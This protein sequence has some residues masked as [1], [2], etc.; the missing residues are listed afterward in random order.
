[1]QCNTMGVYCAQ[2]QI[3]FCDE[4]D[5]NLRCGSNVRYLLPH[6][7]CLNFAFELFC[8]IIQSQ[9]CLYIRLFQNEYLYL[10]NGTSR[11]R[12][13]K[14]ANRKRFP[15][16]KPRRGKNQTNNQV[17]YTIKTYRKTNEQLFS[18]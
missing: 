4:Y 18:Q 13:G 12:S 2:M 17:P 9:Y 15:L 14:G 7:S 5:L 16:Q 6:Q 3:H 1:M 10:E 11:Q 8:F